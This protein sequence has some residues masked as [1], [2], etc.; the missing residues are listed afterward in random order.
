M[1]LHI[2]TYASL[3]QKKAGEGM[4]NKEKR[5]KERVE[6]HFTLLFYGWEPDIDELCNR[7][8]L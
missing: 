7:I 3:F 5:V 1:L 2:P 4:E 8:L 6:V